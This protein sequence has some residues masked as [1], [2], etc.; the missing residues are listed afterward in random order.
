MY[1]GAGAF[2]ILARHEDSVDQPLHPVNLHALDG[3]FRN[4]CSLVVTISP[5]RLAF[6]RLAALLLFLPPVPI[7]LTAIGEPHFRN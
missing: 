3:R 4:F 6:F 5:V 2:G 1:L 7:S